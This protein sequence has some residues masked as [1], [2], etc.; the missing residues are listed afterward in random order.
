M[1]ITVL[2]V[3]MEAEAGAGEP[4]WISMFES[5]GPSTLRYPWRYH[6][7]FIYCT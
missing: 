7:S 5:G 2:Y 3:I 1:Y 4:C 6:I